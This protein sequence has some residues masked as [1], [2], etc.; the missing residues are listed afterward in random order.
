MDFD[1]R[2]EAKFQLRR[3]D[4]LVCEG[5]EPGR[6]AMWNGQIDRCCYQKSL[7]RLRPIDDAA[8]PQ[9]LV[10]RL[11]LGAG[12]GEFTNDHAKTTIAHLPAVRLA[13]LTIALPGVAE[14]RRIG[15]EL[16]ERLATI[17][18]IARSLKA[19]LETIRAL[20]A[21]LLRRAF[22]QIDDAA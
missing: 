9:F 17:D 22:E 2:E 16:R 13:T 6:A 10:Y 19:E 12:R 3:G 21:A 18:A 14:Q 4:V 20:S 5:G 15:A 1:E 7:H 11:W 8:D